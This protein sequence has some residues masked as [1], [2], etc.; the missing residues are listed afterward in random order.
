MPCSCSISFEGHSSLR[1]CVSDTPLY[2]IVAADCSNTPGFTIPC[3]CLGDGRV[4]HAL[5]DSDVVQ[6][7]KTAMEGN[8]HR[9]EVLQVRLLMASAPSLLYIPLVGGCERV[10]CSWPDRGTSGPM[11]PDLPTPQQR[12]FP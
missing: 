5:V 4:L 10:W 6:L 2:F 9:C 11:S 3:R 8:K 7:I 12:D 1:L